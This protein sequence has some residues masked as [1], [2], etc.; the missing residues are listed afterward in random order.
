MLK[1]IIKTRKPKNCEWYDLPLCIVDILKTEY[2]NGNLKKI[3]RIYRNDTEMCSEV[4]WEHPDH[5]NAYRIKIST[6]SEY[7]DWIKKCIADGYCYSSKR[8]IIND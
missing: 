5:F 3:Q 1:V 7:K 2:A 4:I 8:E 6:I